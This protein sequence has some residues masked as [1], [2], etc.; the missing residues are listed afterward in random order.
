LTDAERFDI[1][2]RSIHRVPKLDDGKQ[3]DAYNVTDIIMER[4]FGA[5]KIT[6]V[7][8]KD[9]TYYNVGQPDQGAHR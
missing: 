7:Q 9:D 3:W 5:W 8:F 4:L 1:L 6:Q 2:V